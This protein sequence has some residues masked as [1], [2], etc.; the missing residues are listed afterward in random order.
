MTISI[1][2]ISQSS[3]D[4]TI[5]NL[6]YSVKENF[7][8]I[9]ENFILTLVKRVRKTLLKTVVTQNWDMGERSGSTL[10]TTKTAGNL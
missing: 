10:N 7:I 4:F 6:Q 9:L 2:K 1:F 5:R 8:L 3:F